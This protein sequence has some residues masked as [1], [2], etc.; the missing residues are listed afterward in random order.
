MLLNANKSLNE[1]IN[2]LEELIKNLQTQI[3]EKENSF[4]E[5]QDINMTLKN[6]ISILEQAQKNINLQINE[7]ENT[8]NETLKSNRNLK[9][10]INGLEQNVRNLEKENDILQKNKE[11]SAILQEYKKRI[12]L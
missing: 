5:L 9:E 7:K 1:K 4:E 3:D 8:I 11:N 10:I 2:R 12:E 6:K